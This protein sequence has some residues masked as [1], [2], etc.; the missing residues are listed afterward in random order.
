MNHAYARPFRG[1]TAQR[2]VAGVV[3]TTMIGAGAAPIAAAASHHGSAAART[4]VLRTYNEKMGSK[5]VTVTVFTRGGKKYRAK[6]WYTG[7][8]A[9]KVKHRYVYLMK[10]RAKTLISATPALA[11]PNAAQRSCTDAEA[12][13]VQS[14]YDAFYKHVQAGHLETSPGDQVD[15]IARDPDAYVKIHTVLVENMAGQ[16][17]LDFGTFPAVAAEILDIFMKHIDAGHLETSPEGQVKDILRA[18]QYVKTHTVLVENMLAPLLAWESMFVAGTPE[19]CT[20]EPAPAAPTAGGAATP[21][22]AAA[23][24]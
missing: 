1:V 12:G 20:A 8:G 21:A 23:D 3:A 5:L 7:A 2:A 6:E 19:D 13:A 17:V 24:T 14:A 15:D 18:D 16:S 11:T 22:P 4:Y 10:G 9:K